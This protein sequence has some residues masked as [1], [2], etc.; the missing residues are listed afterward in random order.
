MISRPLNHPIDPFCHLK[1]CCRR[2]GTVAG[3]HDIRGWHCGGYRGR[4]QHGRH[5]QDHGAE[6]RNNRRDDIWCAIGVEDRLGELR[7]E[8]APISIPHDGLEE[9]EWPVNQGRG[10]SGVDKCRQKDEV[11]DIRQTRDGLADDRPT[12]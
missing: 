6:P 3:A 7:I 12:L 11:D 9:S 1:L 8:R 2:D 5:I 10:F 4:R